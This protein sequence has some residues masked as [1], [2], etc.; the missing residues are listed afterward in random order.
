MKG[1]KLHGAIHIVHTTFIT[2]RQYYRTLLTT[3][4]TW[5]LQNHAGTLIFA[6]AL[7]QSLTNMPAVL[8]VIT[9]SQISI[10]GSLH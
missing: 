6:T 7:E 3:T 5:W 2:Q 1:I 10:Q 9:Q 8:E 4:S